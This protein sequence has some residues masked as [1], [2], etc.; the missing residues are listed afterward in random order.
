MWHIVERR[1][2]MHTVRIV[3]T[4]HAYSHLM[5]TLV[6]TTLVS[7]ELPHPDLYKTLALELSWR[8]DVYR[9]SAAT[10]CKILCSY[11]FTYNIY[12]V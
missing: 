4:S 6:L 7:L 5:E 3:D 9:E 11:Y 12:L 10:Y 2:I 1:V 8:N